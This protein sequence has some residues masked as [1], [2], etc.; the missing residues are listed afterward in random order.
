MIAPAPAP[1]APPITA[2]AARFFL[3]TTAPVPAPI[4][5]PTTA[6]FAV[7]LH[8]FLASA[9]LAD[10]DVI[11]SELLL[12]EPLCDVVC[13]FSATGC[14]AFLAFSAIVVES[15][16]WKPAVLAVGLLLQA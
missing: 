3:L 13:F 1:A 14:V 7:L 6:P 8:P 10:S 16:V 4:T 9:E 11:A 12:A 5:A 15:V 2:P